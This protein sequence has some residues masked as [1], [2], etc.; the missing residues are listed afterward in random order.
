MCAP[1][2]LLE[3]F[4]ISGTLW[5]GNSQGWIFGDTNKTICF[6]PVWLLPFSPLFLVVLCFNKFKVVLS[7]EGE[8]TAIRIDNTSMKKKLGGERLL[9]VS[10]FHEPEAVRALCG[11]GSQWRTRALVHKKDSVYKAAGAEG[12]SC[13]VLQTPLSCPA[14]SPSPC[15]YHSLLLILLCSIPPPPLWGFFQC[16][17]FF[18]FIK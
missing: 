13:T 16:V 5:S 9:I 2:G 12:E 6:N 8:Y 4:L 18:F 14:V 7:C 15:L 3:Y 1:S 17:L 11:S 10:P